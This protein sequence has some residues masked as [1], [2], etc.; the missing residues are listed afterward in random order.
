MRI[1]HKSYAAKSIT[2]FEQRNKSASYNSQG[3]GIQGDSKASISALQ[4]SSAEG[5]PETAIV[6]EETVHDSSSNNLQFL[7]MHFFL[8]FCSLTLSN[9]KSSVQ[10]ILLTHSVK[11]EVKC[12]DYFAHSLCQTGSQVFRLFCSHSVKEE[13]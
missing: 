1:A 4:L 8:S 5:L 7:F 2:F 13:V 6:L 10:T 11:Q 3:E 9:R 12:L